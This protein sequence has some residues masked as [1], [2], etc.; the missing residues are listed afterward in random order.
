MI[1]SKRMSRLAVRSKQPAQPASDFDQ[2]LHGVL[3]AGSRAWPGIPLPARLFLD[4]AAIRVAADEAPISSLAELHAGDLYLACAALHEVAGALAAFELHYLSSVRLFLTRMRPTPVFVEEVQQQL[5][6]RLFVAGSA[7]SPRIAEYSGRGSL[8]NW[9]R[10]I[11]LRAA[12]DLRRSRSDLLSES[13]H[14]IP[15]DEEGDDPEV[16]YIKSRYLG[17]FQ[18]AFRASLRALSTEQRNL[19][20]LHFF[21]GLSLDQLA[22]LF[23]VHRA[24]AARWIAGAR[25]SILDEARRLL[26][27]RLE[28]SPAEF[29]SIACMVRSQLD[30]SITGFLGSAC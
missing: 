7:G 4:H 6:D 17:E 14:H 25:R 23:R 11:A 20:R 26:G 24:T 21:D 15:V 27:D 2:A 30:L 3:L 10:V 9:L 28:M 8:T 22:V 12:I 16:G 13:G 1:E 5:R 29:D 18:A 19:L